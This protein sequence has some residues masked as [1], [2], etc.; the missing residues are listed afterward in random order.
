MKVSFS[1]CLC[2]ATCLSKWP[3]TGPVVLLALLQDA[4]WRSTQ[5]RSRRG[6]QHQARPNMT[7][8]ICVFANPPRG[9]KKLIRE[10]VRCRAIEA[11]E[12]L[13]GAS[14]LHTVEG[15]IHARAGLEPFPPPSQV[16]F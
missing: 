15:R 10:R 2:L 1:K 12:L 5:P 3:I 13:G 16:H 9:K 7:S 4:E 6:P 14:I 11:H 8:S